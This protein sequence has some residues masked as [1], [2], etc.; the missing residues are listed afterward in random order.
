MG[1]IDDS[2]DELTDTT[3]GHTNHEELSSTTNL[4]NNSTI[5]NNG[6]NAE[7]AQDTAIFECV[8]DVSHF[9]EIRSV[10]LHLK[11]AMAAQVV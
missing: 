6:H 8:A 2:S 10:G 3:E 7:C 9:E 11:L 1:S 5:D 4:G